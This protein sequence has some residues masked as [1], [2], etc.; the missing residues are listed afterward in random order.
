MK[1]QILAG[2]LSLAVLSEP[3]SA[4]VGMKVAGLAIKTGGKVATSVVKSMGRVGKSVPVKVA[5][6]AANPR[7]WNLTVKRPSDT[8][9]LVGIATVSGLVVYKLVTTIRGVDRR[10]DALTKEL[11]RTKLLNRAEVERAL[12][13]LFP[14]ASVKI[15]SYDS[16]TPEWE[17]EL[18][19]MYGK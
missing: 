1:K 18:N 7:L 9:V 14:E 17:K 3:V 12:C 13:E 4:G 11:E 15:R 2:L 6:V 8:A 10:I 16:G 19:A 5:P